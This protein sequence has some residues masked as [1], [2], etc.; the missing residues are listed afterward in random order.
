FMLLFASAMGHLL[1]TVQAPRVILATMILLPLL[2]IGQTSLGLKWGRDRRLSYPA[3]VDWSRLPHPD[4]VPYG[5]DGLSFFGWF[6]SVR[7]AAPQACRYLLS[8][9]ELYDASW[10]FDLPGAL[11]SELPNHVAIAH[12]S[13]L[14]KWKPERWRYPPHFVAIEN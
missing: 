14:K 4:P 12:Q 6:R 7:E 3:M 2:I 5:R 13:D 8:V 10:N 9:G 1:R 11:W